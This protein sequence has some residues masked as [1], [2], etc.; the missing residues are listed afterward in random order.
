MFGFEKVKSVLKS[1]DNSVLIQAI[2]G[3]KR[4]KKRISV[5]TCQFVLSDCLTGSE[6]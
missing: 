5:K 6:L 4:E 3:S 2:D 1:N